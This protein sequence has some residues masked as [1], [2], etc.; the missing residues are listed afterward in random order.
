MMS[1][2]PQ[3]RRTAEKSRFS[4]MALMAIHHLLLYACAKLGAMM[5]N[6]EMV[7]FSLVVH[8]A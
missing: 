1:S 6:T 4:M 3:P 8:S 5:L 7:Q 2:E